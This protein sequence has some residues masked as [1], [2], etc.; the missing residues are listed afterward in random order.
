MAAN[1]CALLDD[2]SIF[3]TCIQSTETTRISRLL[4]FSV[5]INSSIF[6]VLKVTRK[7]GSWKTPWTSSKKR[8]QREQR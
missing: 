2:S 8:K 4:S 5:V 6:R 1:K 7:H 3:I